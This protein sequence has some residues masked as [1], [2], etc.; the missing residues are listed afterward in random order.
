VAVGA[1]DANGEVTQA[2]HGAWYSAGADLGGVL[3]EGNVTD[4]VQR[5]DRPVAAQ[6]VGQPGGAGLSEVELVIA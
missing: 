1:Q 6:Q 2:G 4:V 3:G 5:L